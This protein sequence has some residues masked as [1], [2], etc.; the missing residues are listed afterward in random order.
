MDNGMG[1]VSLNM[2]EEVSLGVS[3]S[4]KHKAASSFFGNTGNVFR[5]DSAE[6]NGGRRQSGKNAA[7]CL[8]VWMS[9][10]N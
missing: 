8:V 4:G 6:C 3:C 9:Q 1:F 2:W 5:M 10:Q 7:S